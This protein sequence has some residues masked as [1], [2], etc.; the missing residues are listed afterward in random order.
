MYRQNPSAPRR[1]MSLA[2]P[3]M[4]TILPS[5][6]AQSIDQSS[7]IWAVSPPT[8]TWSTFAFSG[9]RSLISCSSMA[10]NSARS[11]MVRPSF[12][13]NTASGAYKA[14]IASIFPE[15]NRLSRDGITPSASVG[16]GKLSDIRG[17]L[18]VLVELP[19]G[20]DAHCGSYDRNA[21]RTFPMADTYR[22]HNDGEWRDASRQYIR[23][24]RQVARAVAASRR[25]ASGNNDRPSTLWR[26]VISLASCRAR[27]RLSR[28]VATTLLSK[29]A[30][31]V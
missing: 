9:R 21:G 19:C 12:A 6:P 2:V 30:E 26:E 23:K 31:I 7:T 5:G 20:D 14:I 4:C 29:V 13:T 3:C 10:V 15:L 24:S 28:V 25:A 18:F 22:F 8:N 11:V 1:M 16:R 17:L 27:C